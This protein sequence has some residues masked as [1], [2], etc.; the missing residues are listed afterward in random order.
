MFEIDNT[1]QLT[2]RE[3]EIL[4]MLA[5]GRCNKHIAERL[6][7]TIRTVKFHTNNIFTKLSVGSR[8][9][10]IAWAWKQREIQDLSED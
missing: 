10:A 7:I 5:E 8:A 3:I 6:S 4:Q 1:C 2:E 9:E